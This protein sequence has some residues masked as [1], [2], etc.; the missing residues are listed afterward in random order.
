MNA[1]VIGHEQ[2]IK[3]M[4]AERYL[5]GE[6]SEEERD[7]Y[8]AHLFDCQVCFAQVKA[9]TE[10]VGYI[11]QAGAQEPAPAPAPQPL[12]RHFL[13]YLSRPVL[14]PVFALLCLGFATL[15]VYQTSVIRQLETSQAMASP[16]LKEAPRGMN[17]NHV[18]A[19]RNGIF[20]LHLLFAGKPDMSYEGQIYKDQGDD[21]TSSANS[22]AHKGNIILK[23]FNISGMDAQDPIA[24]QLYSG[25]LR[26]GD[27]VLDVLGAQDGNPKIKVATYYFQLRFQK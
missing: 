23:S 16:M 18:T 27:Y 13:G 12:S 4:M 22:G 26:E 5:L 11:K 14:T 3:N 24:V 9:G 17:E 8:E 7:A 15:S 25:D 19:S 20:T 2:A 1:K 21:N 6:L 10:F